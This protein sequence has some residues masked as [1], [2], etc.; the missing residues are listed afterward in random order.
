LILGL[1]LWMVASFIEALLRIGGGPPT[2]MMAVVALGIL[3][4]IGGP[5]VFWVI[6]PIRDRRRRAREAE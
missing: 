3:V 4:M 2:Y 5:I 6:I 1:I